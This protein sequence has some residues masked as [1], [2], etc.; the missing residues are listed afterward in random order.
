MD[1]KLGIDDCH[2]VGPHLAGPR[3][4]VGGF[5]RFLHL[6]QD[7][8]IGATIGAGRYFACLKGGHRRRSRAG[9]AWTFKLDRLRL[10]WSSECPCECN[11]ASRSLPHRNSA[12][13]ARLPVTTPA[14]SQS[15]LATLNKPSRPAEAV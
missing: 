4:V 7:F 9:G 2:R 3:R 6:V 12:D 10:I 14:L 5:R 8:A 1:A 11:D 13:L 15:M